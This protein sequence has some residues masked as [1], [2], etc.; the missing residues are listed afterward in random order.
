MNKGKHN[1]KFLENDNFDA[2][3]RRAARVTRAKNRE[4]LLD[5]CED[6]QYPFDRA[7]AC[8]CDDNEKNE[9]D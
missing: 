9:K 6:C 3:A 8:A 7:G 1:K 5:R 2:R 4:S